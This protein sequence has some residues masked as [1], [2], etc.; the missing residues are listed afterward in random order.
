MSSGSTKPHA[1]AARRSCRCCAPI[2]ADLFWLRD[3]G[4][5]RTSPRG[6]RLQPLVGEHLEVETPNPRGA[7]EPAGRAAGRQAPALGRGGREEP[8]A[9]LRGRRRPAQP[10][11]DERPLD[12][13][14]PRM[15]PA[16]RPWLVL[17]GSRVE[18]RQWNGPVL[19]LHARSISAARPGHPRRRRPTSTRMLANLRREDQGRDVGDAILDQRLVAGIGNKWKAEAL[20]AARLSPWRRLGAASGRGA[21]RRA[22]GIRDADAAARWTGCRTAIRSTAASAGRA[23]AAGRR[24]ARGARA[25]R[26]GSPTGVLAARYRESMPVRAPAS[27]RRV[28]AFCLAA[29]ADL[30]PETGAPELPFVVEE[31]DSGLLRVPPARPRRRRGARL[32]ARRSAGRPVRRRGAAPRPG[33]ARSSRTAVDGTAPSSRRSCSPW[34]CARPRRAAASTGR[35]RRSS[36]SMPSWS[37]RC[38]ARRACTRRSRRSSGSRS[39]PGSSSGRGSPC[40]QATAE[41]LGH[42]PGCPPRFG[43]E[44]ERSCVLEL[45]RELP[46][47]EEEPPDAPAELAAAVT[48]LRLATGAARRRR[49]RRARPARLAPV[50]RSARCPGSPRPSRRASRAG[51]TRGAAELAGELLERLGA[52]EDDAELTEAVERWELSL[53]EDEPLRSDRLRE[54]LAALLGGPDG[55]WA[56]AMRATL[57]LG[58]GTASARAVDRL[59]AL[60]RGERAGRPGRDDVRRAIVETLLHDDRARLITALDESLLGLRPRPAGYFSRAP[61][62]HDPAQTRHASAAT[63][64]AWRK[65]ARP[66]QARA[67]RRAGARPLGC[68]TSCACAR[69]GGLGAG[70][71]GVPETARCPRSRPS[72]AG[73]TSRTLLA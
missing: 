17:R 24:S 36:A 57:L 51:S 41:E 37:A 3:A 54:S 12:R 44:P 68:R 60:A 29:F 8:A 35:T 26:T 72:N 67:H 23:R 69:G 11:A 64:A 34:S 63:V 49:P 46:A 43:D 48:A 61:A 16:G 13:R 38:T 53:F 6:P 56:A 21:A 73:D 33:G 19:E 58:D 10:S 31:H 42:E 71:G 28:R 70:R 18:A 59:R 22:R 5:R 20:W 40:A 1:T 55:L 47:E 45:E 25:T 39:G 50:R 65:H 66:R 32:L 7:V 2:H 62:R 15:P 4:G 52:S 14:A 30:L 27:A 9:P